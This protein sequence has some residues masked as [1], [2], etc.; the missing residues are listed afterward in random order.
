MGQ[1]AEVNVAFSFGTLEAKER[2]FRFVFDLS[3]LHEDETAA[4]TSRSSSC[5]RLGGPS[6][7]EHNG[8]SSSR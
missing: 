6:A 3:V 5:G 4:A 7:R 1:G 2:K 8:L